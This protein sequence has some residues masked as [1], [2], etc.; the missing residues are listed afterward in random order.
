[1]SIE[2]PNRPLAGSIEDDDVIL[3]ATGLKVHFHLDEGRLKSVDGVDLLIRKGKTLG[4]VGESGC[5]KSVT[6]QA[7]LRIV[8]KPGRV[9]GEILLKRGGGETKAEVVDLAKLDGDGKEIRSVRGGEIAMI[10]QEPMKAFSPIHTVGNQIMEAILLH[11]TNDKKEAREIALETL[12]S[13]GMS[14]PRQRLDE[15]PHQ[16]SGGMRQRAMI[17]MALASHPKILIADEPTTALDVTVQAQ[18]LMLIN[19][20]KE[21]LGTSVVFITHD[22]GVIAEMSD[23]VAVMYLGKVVE[24]TDVD[25][26]FYGPRHPYT[27][28]LLHSIPSVAHRNARLESIEGSVPYPMNLPAG[29]GF[30]SRCPK[31]QAGAC[32]VADIPLIKVKDNHYVRCLFAEDDTTGGGAGQ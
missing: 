32:N 1:M 17:A 30:Y 9:E 25:T 27:K 14:N 12:A 11:R 13:V 7:L 18:V 26:L 21:K 16:L 22:L 24:Y 19:R 2:L 28:A 8:P 4:I 3:Q 6:S 15:Y 29:C 5:G 31:A 23:E 20:L 10:F